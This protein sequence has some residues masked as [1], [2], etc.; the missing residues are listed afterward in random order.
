[1]AGKL[2]K[3]QM[4]GFQHWKGLTTENHLGAIFQQSPQKA[5]NLMVRLLAFHRGKTFPGIGYPVNFKG[6]ECRG[7]GNIQNPVIASS[8]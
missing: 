8:S 5:T 4:I 3:F 7:R 2:S 1:M 6:R